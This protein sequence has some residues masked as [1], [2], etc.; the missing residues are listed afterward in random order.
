M[1]LRYFIQGPPFQGALSRFIQQHRF[2]TSFFT[3]ENQGSLSALAAHLNQ[4]ITS[5]H[6][7]IATL[8]IAQLN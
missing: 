2:F 6:N 3:I 4:L 1:D 8:P 5:L 7:A